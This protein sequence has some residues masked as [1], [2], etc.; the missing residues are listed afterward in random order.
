VSKVKSFLASY[1]GHLGGYLAA[2][3]GIVGQIDPKLLPPQYAFL[4][5]VAGLVT[6]VAHNGFKAGQT[7]AAVQA[8]AQ[9]ATKA[10]TAAAPVLL[11]GILLAGSMGLSGCTTAQLAKA[12][13]VVTKVNAAV[14]SPQA[15]PVIKAAALVAVGTAEAKG[16]TAAQIVSICNQAL[17][18][19]S[20]AGA[21]LSAVAGVVNAQL[22]K[23]NLPAADLLAAEVIEQGFAATI[24]A[25]LGANPTLAQSQ[26]A[27]ADVLNAVLAAAGG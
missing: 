12:N 5:S 18:A 20:G 22:A 19:D 24:Q 7:S 6:V 15:Q 10:L 9:A 25:Q 4:T 17:A 1:A 16:I 13:A 21:S 3:A 14:T 27:V 23:L 2:A 8:A 26:A 11:V